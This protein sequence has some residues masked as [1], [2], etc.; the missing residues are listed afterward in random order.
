MRAF[1]KAVSPHSIYDKYET[2]TIIARLASLLGGW[3]WGDAFWRS[4]YLEF[5]LLRDCEKPSRECLFSVLQAGIG[6][7]FRVC[8]QTKKRLLPSKLKPNQ[9]Q[10]SGQSAGRDEA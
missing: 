4:P 6:G 8:F 2:T 10:L 9:L 5:G 7:A 1:E 3:G